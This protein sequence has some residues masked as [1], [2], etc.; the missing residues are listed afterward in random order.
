MAEKRGMTGKLLYDFPTEAVLEVCINGNFYRTTAKE[1]RSFDG[2]RRISEVVKQ[3]KIG[4]SFSNIEYNVTMY[5]GPVYEYSTNRKVEFT[6]SNK[7][8]SSSI[9]ETNQKVNKK[10]GV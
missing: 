3:P 2:V 6:G 10:R 5:E 7:I 9:L 8:V 4:E 1:F